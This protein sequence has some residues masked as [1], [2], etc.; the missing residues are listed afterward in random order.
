MYIFLSLRLLYPLP[1]RLLYIQSARGVTPAEN[2]A[3]NTQMKARDH[4]HQLRCV[5]FGIHL[6]TFS[7]IDLKVALSHPTGTLS[8]PL[9][10]LRTASTS[11]EMTEEP[12]RARRASVSFYKSFCQADLALFLRSRQLS[13]MQRTSLL[14][15]SFLPNFCVTSLTLLSPAGTK[16]SLLTRKPLPVFTS[17]RKFSGL[18]LTLCTLL[19]ALLTL[20]W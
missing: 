9:W 6:L 1:S 5:A 17:C 3:Y 11:T 13:R 15:V 2:D 18:S 19:Q 4:L 8:L 7:S 16:W 10:S 12:L 20:A 14:L